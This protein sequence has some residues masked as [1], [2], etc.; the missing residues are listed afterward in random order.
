MNAIKELCACKVNLYLDVTGRRGDG[1]HSVRSLMHSLSLSDEVTV[2]KASGCAGVRITVIG[3]G[4]LPTDDRNL[5]VRAAKAFTSVLGITDSINITLKK[6]IPISAGL[7]GGSTDAAGV[8]RALNKLY[9]RPMTRQMLMKLA[10]ELGSDVPYCL[11]G[12]SAI[13]EG[14]GEI[15]KKVADISLHTVVAIS[16]EH[17][18]TPEAYSLLDSKYDGF[19]TEAQH[20]KLSAIHWLDGGCKEAFTPDMLYNIFEEV[21]L[22]RCERASMIKRIMLENSALSALMSGSGPSIFG[23]FNTE[24]DARVCAAKLSSLGFFAKYA[25]SV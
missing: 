16:N 10:A 4:F 5:A 9:R 24:E 20:G 15:I 17:V 1:F 13:C 21:I 25:R 12:G 3:A 7:A 18:S 6:N 14:R 22:E 23:I 8:L 11:I 19:K 2:S